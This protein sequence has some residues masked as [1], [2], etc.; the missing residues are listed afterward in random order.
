MP[1]QKIA[2]RSLNLDDD[3]LVVNNTEM[4]DAQNV[5]VS[6]DD[7]G[8]ANILKMVQG[9]S[10]ATPISGQ[11]APVGGISRTVGSVINKADNN[12][13]FFVANNLE[14]PVSTI[15]VNIVSGQYIHT[16]TPAEVPHVVSVGD[17]I[18]VSGMTNSSR[19]NGTFI[20][21]TVPTANT[22]TY[23][24]GAVT[25]TGTNLA[26]GSAKCLVG[27]HSIYCYLPSTQRTYLAYRNGVLGWTQETFVKADTI[28]KENGDTILY[29][30]DSVSEPR[31]LNVTRALQTRNPSVFS[32]PLGALPAEFESPSSP[33]PLNSDIERWDVLICAAKQ[34][35][36]IAPTFTFVND[37]TIGKNNMYDKYFQFACQYIYDDGEVSAIS[38]YSTL[39]ISNEQFLDGLLSEQQKLLNNVIRVSVTNSK[40]DVANIRILGR[41]KNDGQFFAIDEIA[42]NKATATS[43][44]DFKNDRSYSYLPDSEVNK[45]YDNLPQKANTQ[46]IASNRLMYGGYTEFYDNVTTDVESLVR[47][48]DQSKFNLLPVTVPNASPVFGTTPARF[49]IDL[50]PLGN[51]LEQ[52]DN[53][54]IDILFNADYITVNSTNPFAFSYNSPSGVVSTTFNALRLVTND[55][56]I[57]KKIQFNQYTPISSVRTQIRDLILGTYTVG[58]VSTF[59]INNP[60]INNGATEIAPN[61]Y[62]FFN[63][64]I[65]FEVYN[66]ISSGSII[67]FDVRLRGYTLS[68]T[69]L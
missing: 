7:S 5:T 57:N 27:R 30:T 15:I 14:I 43:T 58:A 11:D 31:K 39:A 41:N 63:G 26:G 16:V 24:S 67:S 47:Y 10:L 37:T 69:S 36:L 2:P 59:D 18:T 53:V 50:A 68:S 21:R 45:L 12:V 51:F 61:T 34:P 38:P 29:F 52:Y 54:D 6:A 3:F 40:L 56:T 17:V 28:V 48:N 32:S 55:F 20:V 4:V 64:S 9:T 35:P 65:N 1:V 25:P 60:A 8:N 66:Y 42:N 13:Y 23:V 46:A 22:F 33:T 49:T 44:Y 62:A 19:D